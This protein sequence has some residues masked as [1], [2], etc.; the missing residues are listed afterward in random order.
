MPRNGLSFRNLGFHVAQFEAA[1]IHRRQNNPVE[2][3]AI[4]HAGDDRLAPI[5]RG[6]DL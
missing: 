6:G 3:Q 4:D 1:E 2:P 5:G